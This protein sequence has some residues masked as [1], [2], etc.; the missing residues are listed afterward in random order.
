MTPEY[1]MAII[2]AAL[3]GDAI[4]V[5]HIRPEQFTSSPAKEVWSAY[6]AKAKSA[7][8]NTPHLVEVTNAIKSPDAL[9]LVQEAQYAAA[10]GDVL[11]ACIER[12]QTEHAKRCAIEALTAAHRE[13]A[14]GGVWSA[15]SRTA[16]RLTEIANG[17]GTGA[18]IS[19]SVGAMLTRRMAELSRAIETG[20]PLTRTVPSGI[21]VLDRATGGFP[22][23]VVSVVAAR[24]GMGKSLLGL[25][26]AMN[27]QRR[28]DG[29]H[30]FSF[31]DSSQ[32]YCDRI[33]ASACGVSVD[34]LR[35][36]EALR[37]GF[38][39][40]QRTIGDIMR[41]PWLVCSQEAV[42]PGEIGL[43]IQRNAVENKT[44]I[45]IVDYLNIIRYSGRRMNRHEQIAETI[46]ELAKTARDLN[47]A[48]VVMAQASRK[49][50]ERADKRPMLS[51]LKESGSIE[52]RAK[53]VIGLY[54]PAYYD[55]AL[56]KSELELNVLKNSNGG[57]GQLVAHVDLARMTIR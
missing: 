52:E 7:A 50:E 16:E 27:A 3:L 11:R 9:A 57:V 4:A 12:L 18:D 20:E 48:M 2:G 24:P 28:G 47:I 38:R 13:I 56:P 36:V 5:R 55:D 22:R 49:A 39:E 34:A 46:N 33:I 23:G 45:V 44:A 15:L 17:D 37:P 43:T 8:L 26:L 51:D 19:E 41:S 31:E 32:A 42:S 1:E 25:V 29:A 40:M 53:L 6:T 10:H 21:E 54:R 35:S 30:V 14:S